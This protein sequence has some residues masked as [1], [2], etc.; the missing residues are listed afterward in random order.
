MV[1]NLY[2]L[3]FSDMTKLCYSNCLKLYPRNAMILDVGIGNGVMIKKNH[4]LIKEKNL[5]ITGLDIN[6]HYLE[7]CRKMIHEFKLEQQVM[8]LHKSILSFSPQ[9]QFCYDYIFFG[10]SFM[11]MNDQEKILERT[12]EW[13]KPD[14]K[15]VFFQTMFKNKSKLM[16]FVKP[17]LKFLT[18]VDFGKVT[19]EKDFYELLDQGNFSPCEDKLLK[20]NVFKGEHRLIIT[21]PE[22]VIQN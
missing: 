21:Q 10:Q 2:N 18:T 6:R 5:R 9:E 15:V 11:L 8:V 19:Y 7:H 16:E 22:N 14:G 1:N 3:I 17:R 20:K 4:K 12:R 13:L